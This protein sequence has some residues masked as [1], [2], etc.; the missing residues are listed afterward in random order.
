MSNYELRAYNTSG[1]LIGISHEIK[2][3]KYVRSVNAIGA[4]VAT[5]PMKDYTPD[6]FSPC[7]V[8]EIWRE[9]NREISLQN[10]TAYFLQ[11]WRFYRDGD[12]KLID[13][14]ALDANWLLDTRIVAYDAGTSQAD[15]TDNA[16]DM[17]KAVVKDN[18]GTDAV[19]ARQ[20]SELSIQGDL[21]DGQSISKAFSY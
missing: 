5:V 8:L 18:L 12:E 11:R 4:M 21:G 10:E 19:T 15:M 2:K 14:V 13:L 17:I 6:D 9:H 1:D 7:V 3:L 20:V 16:D